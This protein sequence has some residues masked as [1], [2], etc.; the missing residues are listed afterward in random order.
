MLRT[1]LLLCLLAT[2]THAADFFVS[3][4][5]ADTNPGTLDK[6]FAT[7]QRAQA[8][9]SPGDTVHLR[10]GTYKLTEEH[11]ARKQRIW[12]YV[13]LLDKSGTKDK[14]I[15]YWAYKDE[16]PVFDLAAVK[17]A[18]RVHAFQVTGSWLHL[19]GIEVIGV[20]VTIKTHA[21]SECFHNEGSNNIYENLSMHDGMAIGFYLTRGSNNLILNCDAYRNHDSFSEDGRG[22]NTDGF[23]AHPAK[24]AVNN[25]FRG[26]RAWF[27]SD[28]GYDCISAD[29]SVTF[30][31]C[32]AMYNGTNE[33]RER[34]ANGNGFKVGGFGSTPVAKL[35]NPIPRHTTRFCLAVGNRANGFYANHQIGG[36]D[37]FNN[38]AFR[39]GN[40]FNMLS[41]LADN[42]TDVDGYG[43]K[44]RNN[45]S[46]K[47]RNHII[48]L[49]AAKSDSSH[50]SFDLNLPITDKDFQSLDE[51]QLTAPRP[52][53]GDLPFITFMHL[54]DTSSLIDKGQDI[55]F[56]FK[57]KSPDLG[58]FE[59]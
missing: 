40:N 29:E 1:L 34:L 7:V 31:N 38:S 49:D 30:E 14:P 9:A 53:S 15:R 56:K 50:N 33:K 19:K 47:S 36:A 4:N 21:Q 27:N 44:L 32:W 18:L 48:R 39:N 54:S 57:G 17:P 42:T 58:A 3:P 2:T 59:R 23:G 45:L 51:S 28:D 55:G 37:W 16:K 26:C 13:T 11:I 46:Y 10:G 12:A 6:P 5:G 41:R 20:Q 52:A 35:P 22:E 25:V 43:H 24:G 8:A